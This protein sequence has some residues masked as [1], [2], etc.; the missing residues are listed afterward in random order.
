MPRHLLTEYKEE[1][2][3]FRVGKTAAKTREGD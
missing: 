3:S 2:I 1:K